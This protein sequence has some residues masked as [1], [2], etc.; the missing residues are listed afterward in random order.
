MPYLEAGTRVKH[1]YRP[2]LGVGVVKGG[3]IP[4]AL[5]QNKAKDIWAIVHWKDY[6]HFSKPREE[7]IDE[8]TVV[9][10]NKNNNQD[11]GARRRTMK[12]RGSRR[13]RSYRKK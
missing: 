12:R 1:K 11:G 13:S 2:A 9:K 5:N 8:L 3:K 6:P 7:F 4:N 10:G